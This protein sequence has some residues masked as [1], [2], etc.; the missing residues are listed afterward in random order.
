[1]KNYDEVLKKCKKCF[2]VY[3]KKFSEDKKRVII[4]LAVFVILTLAAF[5]IDLFV[6]ALVNGTP[7]TRITL[8]RELEKQGG[9]QVLD[10]LITE[11]LIFQEASKNNIKV[12]EADLD[13]EVE[14]IQEELTLQGMDLESTLLLQGQTMQD[15]R[16]NIK[17]KI[18]V[19]KLLEGEIDV[20][21]EEVEE[22]F[23]ESKDFYGEDVLL[24]DV[25]EEIR[26][27]LADQQMSLKYQE[28]LQEIK[29]NSDI[30]Y[31]ISY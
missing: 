15:F 29:T 18:V 17:V 4:I 12:T 13:K 14:L 6:V 8:I 16:R 1:M 5:R 24:E 3:K 28:W 21:D 30:K 7:I 20:T 22:Y 25:K 11:S 23:D 31:L 9:S 19:E 26:T 2:L 27:Q 10:Q